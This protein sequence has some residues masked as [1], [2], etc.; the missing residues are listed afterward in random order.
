MCSGTR[1][2][3]G[4]NKA[5]VFMVPGSAADHPFDLAVEV[6]HPFPAPQTIIDATIEVIVRDGSG[7][8][9]ANYPAADIWLECPVGA[10]PVGDPDTHTGLVACTGGVIADQSSDVNG[11]T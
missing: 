6:G 3:T 10:N 5:I 2:D 7:T 9:I 11:Y 8:V 4:G 1:V